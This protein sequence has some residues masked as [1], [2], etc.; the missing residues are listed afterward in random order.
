MLYFFH[1]YELPALLEQTAMGRVRAMNIVL[2]NANNNANGNNEAREP[3]NNDNGPRIRRQPGNLPADFHRAFNVTL[4]NLMNANG[5][6]NMQLW[7][8]VFRSLRNNNRNDNNNNDTNNRAEDVP[9]PGP[10]RGDGA[11]S[12]VISEELRTTVAESVSPNA[13]TVSS[14]SNVSISN[15]TLYQMPLNATSPSRDSTL[16][17]ASELECS[18][19]SSKSELENSNTTEPECSSNFSNPSKTELKS[20]NSTE[21]ECSS[22]FSNP[23]KI[24]LKNSNTTEL[25]C[26]SNSSKSELKSSN[27]TELHVTQNTYSAVD[28]PFTYSTPLYSCS[29]IVRKESGAISK[30]SSGSGTSPVVHSTNNRVNSSSTAPPLQNLNLGASAPENFYLGAQA[31]SESTADSASLSDSER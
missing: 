14:A 21:P 28:T 11:E 16:T 3:G 4:R 2:R 13:N 12:P 25:E 6:R 20:S 7:R 29:K 26:S 23:S 1:H 19:N 15:S 22:N 5:G 31:I 8:L 27:T 17:N 24:E 30:S 18:S 10:E 9:V